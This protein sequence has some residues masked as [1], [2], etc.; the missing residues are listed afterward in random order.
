MINFLARED[1]VNSKACK[2]MPVNIKQD[3]QE[4]T[5]QNCI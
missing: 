5:G 4:N 2:K 1:M 3:T